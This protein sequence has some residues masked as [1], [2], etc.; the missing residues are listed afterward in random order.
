MPP[1]PLMGSYFKGKLEEPQSLLVNSLAMK[2]TAPNPTP[3][4]SSFLK[5]KTQKVMIQ[6][7]TEVYTEESQEKHAEEAHHSLL[8]SETP[9][10]T[11][12]VKVINNP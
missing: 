9:T 12:E 6:S 3:F 11:E 2:G 5:R 10:S 1:K 8:S 4:F 7:I